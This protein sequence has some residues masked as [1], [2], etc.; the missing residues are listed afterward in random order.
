MDGLQVVVRQ[1]VR[2]REN[3]Y[4]GLTESLPPVWV[5]AWL[6]WAGKGSVK[7]V[8]PKACKGR[9]GSQ[10]QQAG[11]VLVVSWGLGVFWGCPAVL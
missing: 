11:G 1:L 9:I 3:V 6:A 10:Q 5:G 2:S 7:S 8:S 4:E